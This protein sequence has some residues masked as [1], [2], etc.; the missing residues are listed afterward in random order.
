[1]MKAFAEEIMSAQEIIMMK[2]LQKRAC[3]L[4]K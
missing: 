1:M 3:L 4:R 2:R